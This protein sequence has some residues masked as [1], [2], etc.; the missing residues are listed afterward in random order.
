MHSEMKKTMVQCDFDGTIT[1]E[2][3]S[4]LL[5]DT[6]ADGDWRQLL[7]EYR[8]GKMS[9]G[10]FNERAFAM[11]KADKQT[12]L[13]FVFASGKVKI[14]PGFQ[15]LLAY[16]SQKGLDF[17]I[18]SNGLDFYIEAILRDLGIKNIEFFAAQCHFSADGM[19]VK[20]IGPDGSPME[21][22]FKDAYTELFLS[23]GYQVVYVGNGLSDLYPARL[24]HHV[25]AT[26]D[27]LERCHEANLDCTPFDD[28]NDVVRGLEL[29]QPG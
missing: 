18:V 24:A 27:L 22:R 3:V 14:R 13:D 19:Q 26:G 7:E 21:H 1:E 2:D 23:R 25:F 9:V 4:F 8:E 28:L 15:E 10:V 5:M 12:L 29:L 6:F 17:V 11:V 16:C 20:Y